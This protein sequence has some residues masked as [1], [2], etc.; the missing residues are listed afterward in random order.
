MKINKT[1]AKGYVKVKIKTHCSVCGE[2]LKK[3]KTIYFLSGTKE[4]AQVE[5]KEQVAVWQNKIRE[6]KNICKV[7]KTIVK[8]LLMK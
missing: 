2:I 3:Q 5:V 4:A 7:C 6:Q 8:Q 1:D